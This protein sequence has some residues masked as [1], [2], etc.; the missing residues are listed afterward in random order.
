MATG[1]M[2]MPEI[3][4][5]FGLYPAVQSGATSGETPTY[6]PQPWQSRP[7]ADPYPAIIRPLPASPHAQK[8]Q[9]LARQELQ[10][11][12]RG[13]TAEQDLLGLLTAA[14]GGL[15]GT[16]LAE[17]ADVPLWEA[18]HVLR[19]V[20]R[21]TFENRPSLDSPRKRPDVY[22]L[23]HEELQVAAIDYL[24]GRLT[25]YRDRLHAWA[26]GYRAR[27]WPAETPEYLLGGY[28]RLLENLADLPRM[29]ECA[30]D[31]A[32][33]DRML[34]LSGGDAA[35]L[36][37]VRTALDLIAAQDIPDLG[38]A[39][40]LAFH[41]DHLARRNVGIPVEL[42]AVW[43]TLGYPTRAQALAYSIT[44]AYEQVRSLALLMKA[45]AAAGQDNQVAAVALH[46]EALAGSIAEPYSPEAALAEVARALA[47]T[48]RLQLAAVVA[49]RAEAVAR[50]DIERSRATGAWALVAG[51]LA[52]TGQYEKAENM[53]RSIT[54]PSSQV[55]TLVE[56][57]RALAA[58]GQQEQAGAVAS[59]TPARCA[60]ADGCGSV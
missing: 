16:D 39:L 52:A 13:R 26:A 15:S 23:G 53:A 35:A 37:E 54:E 44:P 49:G 8:V 18:E 19:T 41:R 38:N 27:G 10:R 46:A 45:L 36:A 48:G 50:S 58:T 25:R 60:S 34:D 51:T 28:F 57:A 56:V 11:L 40:R 30:C 20:A 32:R 59:R 33:H 2:F 6:E 3:S 22:L 21:R 9:R 4:E 12:L 5:P 1:R 17:L 43:A 7:A 47:A 31:M 29:V 55:T 14:L 42:P 24:G